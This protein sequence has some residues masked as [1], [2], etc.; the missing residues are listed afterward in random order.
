MLPMVDIENNNIYTG[1]LHCSMGDGPPFPGVATSRVR[2]R[3]YDAVLLQWYI[4][5]RAMLFGRI[6]TGDAVLLEYMRAMLEV[7][8]PMSGDHWDLS[9]ALPC[10]H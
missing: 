3:T 8:T 9:N 1:W 10:T 4:G 5:H 2:I 6:Y 7:A